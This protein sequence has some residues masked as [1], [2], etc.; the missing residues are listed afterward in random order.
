MYWKPNIKIPGHLYKIV[1]DLQGVEI[2][3]LRVKRNYGQQYRD[4]KR[5]F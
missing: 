2:V 4:L 3:T 1:F 5:C